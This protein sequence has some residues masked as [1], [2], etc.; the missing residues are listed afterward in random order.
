MTTFDEAAPTSEWPS[1]PPITSLFSIWIRPRDTLRQIIETDPEYAV[2]F[3]AMLGGF[4]HVLSIASENSLGDAVSFPI[5]LMM[6]ATVG[7]IGGILFLYLMGLLVSWTGGWLGGEGSSQQ[8]RAA[9]A[10]GSVPSLWVGLLWVPAVLIFGMDLF[11]TETPVIESGG[12][13]LAFLLLGMAVLHLVG[14]IWGFVATLK[15]VGEAHCFSAWRALLNLFIASAMLV[16]P[17]IFLMFVLVAVAMS[18]M[19]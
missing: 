16:L 8:V 1:S 19:P 13:L 5:I 9:L 7:P 14:G 18:T 12:P 15:C 4:F 6:A 11:A 2:I 3:L 10:W 17:L